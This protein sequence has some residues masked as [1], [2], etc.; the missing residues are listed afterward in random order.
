MKKSI[1]IL[2]ILLWTVSAIAQQYEEVVYLKNGSRIKGTVIE[3]TS[4]QVKIEIY[5]GSILTYKSDEVEKIVKENK[6][7]T[8]TK[9]RGQRQPKDRTTKCYR[10]VGYSGFLDAGYAMRTS[11]T[12]FEYAHI[13]T[14]H[15]YQFNPYFFAGIG[16][17]AQ[18]VTG[19]RYGEGFDKNTVLDQDFD[20]SDVGAVV[21]ANVRGYLLDNKYTP[22]LDFRIG[23]ATTTKGL[24]L[25][26]TFNAAI[27][28]FDFG[29]GVCWQNIKYLYEEINYNHNSIT[30]KKRPDKEKLELCVIFKIGVNF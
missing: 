5:D 6:S 19:A 30:N 20:G 28:K 26:P 11:D 9:T 7:E 24:Y 16:V 15:G 25:Q 27:G 14:A 2:A 12:G 13:S 10:A 4:E 17:G 18:F 29:A 8:R 3:M 22:Y 21:F 1:F 23:Y